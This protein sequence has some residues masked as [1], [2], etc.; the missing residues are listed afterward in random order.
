MFGV[1]NVYGGLLALP[2]VIVTVSNRESALRDKRQKDLVH[3]SHS[4]LTDEY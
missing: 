2:E 4:I 1:E 3:F